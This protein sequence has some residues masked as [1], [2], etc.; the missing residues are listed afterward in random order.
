MIEHVLLRRLGSFNSEVYLDGEK[1]DRLIAYSI[2]AEAGKEE[3]LEIVF[4]TGHKYGQRLAMQF[5]LSVVDVEWTKTN[6]VETG[7]VYDG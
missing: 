3:K 2:L 4:Y 7:E 5:P 1:V 6:E